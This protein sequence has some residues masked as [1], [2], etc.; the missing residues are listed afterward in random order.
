MD[1]GGDRSNF[2]IVYFEARSVLEKK[3]LVINAYPTV[4][5]QCWFTLIKSDTQYHIAM[6]E[7][8]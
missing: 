5:K 7:A 4:S 1:D 8:P 6:N 2:F 3:S